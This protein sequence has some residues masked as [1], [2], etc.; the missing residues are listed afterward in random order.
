[1]QVVRALT[2]PELVAEARDGVWSPPASQHRQAWALRLVQDGG[3]HPAVQFDQ[4]VG[5]LMSREGG[6]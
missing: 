2:L 1:M 4:L 3:A 6:D 5:L